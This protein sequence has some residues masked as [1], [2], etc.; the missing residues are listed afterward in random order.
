MP[1]K[2]SPVVIERKTVALDVDGAELTVWINPPMRLYADLA[3]ESADRIIDAMR[4]IVVAHPYVNEAGDV[5][6]V[7]D[8]DEPTFTAISKAYGEA[9]RPPKR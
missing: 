7:D 3:S 1:A 5:L 2:Q 4:Q 8:F 9:V 6:A